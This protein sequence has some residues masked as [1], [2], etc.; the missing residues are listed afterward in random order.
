MPGVQGGGGEGQ[1]K[2]G[3]RKWHWHVPGSGYEPAGQRSPSWAGSGG[4]S[5]PGPV[6]ITCNFGLQLLDFYA[7]DDAARREASRPKAGCWCH[8]IGHAL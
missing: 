6:A 4:L 7:G 1:R 2:R 3:E 5:G 8:E